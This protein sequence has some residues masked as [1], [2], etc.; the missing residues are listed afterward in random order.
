M[1]GGEYKLNTSHLSCLPLS[2]TLRYFKGSLHFAF[3]FRHSFRIWGSKA[4]P[5]QPIKRKKKKKSKTE[6]IMQII[7]LVQ[8]VS[9]RQQLHNLN[10]GLFS[11]EV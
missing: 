1:D 10:F 4:K 3:F 7:V 5:N 11:P 9:L 2:V 8:D 6:R